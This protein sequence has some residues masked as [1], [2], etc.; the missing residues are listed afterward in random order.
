[1]S[2]SSHGKSKH[3][4]INCRVGTN[5]K[6]KMLYT[7]AH[8]RPDGKAVSARLV[9]PVLVNEYGKNDP[10][11]YRVVAWGALAD[12]FAKNLSKGKE[13]TF[14]CDGSSYW[15]NVFYSDGNQVM[16][17]DG[18]AL[19][20][21]Q[22]SFTIRGFLWGADSNGTITEETQSGM[23][24]GEGRRP[25]QW[26]IPGSPDNQVWKQLLERRKQT[27][28]QGGEVFGYAKVVAPRGGGQILTGDQSKI[29]RNQATGN[30]N[31]GAQN[32][33]LV[34]QVQNTFTP[35]AQPVQN[36]QR[37]DPNTGQPINNT[38]VNNGLPTYN[39]PVQNQTGGLPQMPA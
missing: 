6:I 14:F 24:S 4:F 15:G 10:D 26:N 22:T 25:A 18:S 35:P 20:T 39:Q 7:P 12:M 31:V 27:F 1:M 28:Y 36:Q 3:E 5:D 13:M 11:S 37:F 33:N 23:K 17:K 9:I 8:I 32:N 34:N 16:Q 2:G 30:V 21:R 38:P 29:L 19:Q